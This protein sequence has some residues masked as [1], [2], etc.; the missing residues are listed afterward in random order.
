MI[1]KISKYIQKTRNYIL[2]VQAERVL[3]KGS[4]NSFTQLVGIIKWLN[5]FTQLVAIIKWLQRGVYCQ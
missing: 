1:F 2:F 4:W 5:S 3:R